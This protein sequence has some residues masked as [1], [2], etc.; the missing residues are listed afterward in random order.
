VN[1]DY[2]T[3]FTLNNYAKIF[4]LGWKENVELLIF[5]VDWPFTNAI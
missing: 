1:F 5:K 4:A 2:D 3:T